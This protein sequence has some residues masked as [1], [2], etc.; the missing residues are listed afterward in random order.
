MSADLE[1]TR[2]T[3]AFPDAINGTSRQFKL[4][5]GAG[6]LVMQ[7]FVVDFSVRY[8]SDRPVGRIQ[9]CFVYLDIIGA[10]IDDTSDILAVLIEHK[11]D[12]LIMTFVAVPFPDP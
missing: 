1:I 3:L 12:K 2:A 8:D 5:D 6:N 11:Q 10:G 4:I 7:W 9:F